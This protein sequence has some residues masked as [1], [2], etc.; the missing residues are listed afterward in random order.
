M[1]ALPVGSPLWVCA[2]IPFNCST[3]YRLS[4]SAGAL[5]LFLEAVEQHDVVRRRRSCDGEP[6]AV[7]R[8]G[9]VVN[10]AAVGD[11]RQ[12]VRRSAVE[13]LH[14]QIPC[15]VDIR[16]ALARAL[17]WLP[18]VGRD[19]PQRQGVDAVALSQGT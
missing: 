8:P 13:R 2:S 3:T 18:G 14:Q 15:D 6:L 7:A 12:L 9:E 4:R 10:R 19:R 5:A 17:V 16:D 11:V 1:P